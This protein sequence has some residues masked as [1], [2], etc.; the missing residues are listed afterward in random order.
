MRLHTHLTCAQVH[1]ALKQAKEARQVTEDIR[2]MTLEDHK[3]MTHPRAFE[4]QLGTWCKTSLPDGYRDQYGKL[5]HVRRYKNSGQHGASSDQ[6]LGRADCS[7]WSA[8]WHEWGWF[9]ARVFAADPDARF[10]GASGWHYDG[11]ADFNRKTGDRFTGNACEEEINHDTIQE[12]TG[13]DA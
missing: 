10:G 3:S 6:G 9:M 7:V 8:T 11:V 13:V 12:Q 1:G 2:F 4:V 5:M